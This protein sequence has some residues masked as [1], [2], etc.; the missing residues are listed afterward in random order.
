MHKKKIIVLMMASIPCQAMAID[1]ELSA[2]Q[3]FFKQTINGTWYQNAFPYTVDLKSV[4]WST[5]LSHKFSDY[6]RIR[7]EFVNLGIASADALA[8]PIDAY[9]NT[10]TNQCV[11]ECLPLARFV[12]KGG[13]RGVALTIAPEKRFGDFSVFIEGGIYIFRPTY[14]AVV[15]NVRW[16]HEADPITVYTKHNTTTQISYVMG[17]GVRYKQVE[18]VARYYDVEASDDNVPAVYIGAT[19][20]SVRFKF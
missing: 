8:V 5:G 3:T 17:L 6:P 13:V 1:Y 12:S 14:S 16:T 2:G 18:F 7:A 9:Y 19:T 11:G 4:N 15:T 20:V 10:N